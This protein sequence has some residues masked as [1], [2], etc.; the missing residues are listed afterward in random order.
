MSIK[1]NYPETLQNPKNSKPWKF[2]LMEV[3]VLMEEF[4]GVAFLN[5]SKRRRFDAVF[6]QF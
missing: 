4:E 5:V 1:A 3:M 2:R 6:M